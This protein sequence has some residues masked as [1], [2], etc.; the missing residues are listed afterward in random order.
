VT[1]EGAHADGTSLRE[2][3]HVATADDLNFVE[4]KGVLIFV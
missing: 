2:V 1:R 4:E 3:Q